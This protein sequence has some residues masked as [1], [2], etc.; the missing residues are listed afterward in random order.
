M[1][2][3]AAVKRQRYAVGYAFVL[4]II[5]FFGV[6][7]LYPFIRSFYVSLTRWPGFGDPQF[8]GAENF[9][10]LL[11]DPVFWKAL[12][13]T[14]VFTVA[15]TVLQVVLPL[16]L[17]IL[18]S[19]GWRGSVVFRTVF[20]VP[21]VVS[22]VV[23]GLLWQFMYDGDFGQINALLKSIGLGDLQHGWLAD[24]KTVLPAI[25]LVSLWQSLG[26]YMLIYF[27]AIQGIDQSLYEAARVDGANKVK[28]IWNITVPMLRPITAVVVTLNVLGGVKAFELIFV[29]TGGGP[30][31]A[32]EVLGTYLYGLAFGSSAGAVPAIGYATAVS[33]VVALLGIGAVILQIWMA[34]R[35][36]D[37]YN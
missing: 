1:T 23:S 3:A 19:A 11:D 35:G 17:A 2:Q 18:L 26:F 29:M 6:F 31:H 33:M 24:P 37:V 15:T 7:V 22:L 25:M 34:R 36:R 32:S 8:I 20:F 13:V 14:L 4:P 28:E 21:Q 27:A 16:L 5:V 12:R 9:R 30:N 10:N